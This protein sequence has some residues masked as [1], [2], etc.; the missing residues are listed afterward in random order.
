M[1][2]AQISHIAVRAV[3]ILTLTDLAIVL[4]TDKYY[5]VYSHMLANSSLGRGLT[6]W[7][8]IMSLLLP[9]Y[10]GL[11]AWHMR[12]SELKTKSL[13][14]DAALAMVCFLGLWGIVLYAW[15]HYAMF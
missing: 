15:G 13:W 12:G 9:L 3:A 8:I 5:P 6:F 2:A 10:V 7:A 11:E 1:R 4:L 14:I